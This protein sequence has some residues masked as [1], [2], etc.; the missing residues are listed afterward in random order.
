MLTTPHRKTGLV[1]KRIRFSLAYTDSFIR[2]CAMENGHD[3]CYVE[4]KEPVEDR[5]NYDSYKGISEV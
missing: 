4:C 5:V 3:I 2:T 1:K